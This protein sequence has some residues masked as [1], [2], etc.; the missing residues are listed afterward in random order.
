MPLQQFDERVAT[1]NIYVI[2]AA[3]ATD[4]NTVVESPGSGQRV[5]SILLAN[6]DTI[7]HV[8]TFQLSGVIPDCIIGSVNV[9]AGQGF[10]GTP[11]LE[12]IAALALGAVAALI[13]PIGCN[14]NARADVAVTAAKH[15]YVCAMGGMF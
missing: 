11:P 2:T 14:I 13:L 3:D 6:D 8:V 5:D 15:L 1:L 12:A 10:A 9:P 4:F 7:A